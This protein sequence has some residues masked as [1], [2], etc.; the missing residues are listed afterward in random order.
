MST[1]QLKR[2]SQQIPRR[3]LMG[4][5]PS[6]THPRVLAAMSQPLIGHLDP[7]F[8]DLMDETMELLRGVFGTQNQLT[9]PVSATGSA[10][11]EATLCNLI[12]PGDEV[13]VCVNGV[14]GTRMADIVK[15]CR[16][17]LHVVE[18]DWGR[19]IDPEDVENKLKAV[20]AKMVCIVHAE[21]STGVL[22]PLDDI[23]ALAKRY[24]ALLLVDCVTSL[25]GVPVNLDATGI[26][27]TYS[28][29]QKC[30]SCPPGL[31]PVSFSDRAVEIV[32]RRK[33]EVQSWYLDIRMISEYWGENRLYHHT[34]PISMM[35]AINEALKLVHEEGLSQRYHRH[36]LHS[37][38]LAVG[39]E[40]IGVKQIAQEG[41][42][43]PMLTSVSIP[44]GV[45]DT[46]IRRRLLK[47]YN[48]EIGG[49]LG[50]FK[51]KAWR[52]GLMGESCRK[53]SVIRLLSALGDLLPNVSQL[54]GVEAAE[55]VYV[56]E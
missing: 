50:V 38:A 26:D 32:H 28:G 27:V 9:F 34:A 43:A 47:E 10:G 3:L 22:Q 11:M 53:E 44:G 40:S 23:S 7:V 2:G 42:R 39:L 20:N 29:T 14:F 41:C 46:T 13:V 21:T 12:E 52:I 25:S 33:T 45:D 1:S 30:L 18:G 5:G 16:G 15:R 54:T 37:Q 8:L 56:A 51:G 55:E 49:G 19:I 24:D 36:K 4:P 31:S 6:N 48:I 17:N 35:Y